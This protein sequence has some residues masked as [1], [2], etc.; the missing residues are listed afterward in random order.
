MRVEAAQLALSQHIDLPQPDH[1]VAILLTL[2]IEPMTESRGKRG[3]WKLYVALVWGAVQP[4]GFAG[5][6]SNS[7]RPHMLGV[8]RDFADG[9]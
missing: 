5:P 8:S 6:S 9:C 7:L 4:K 3:L 1:Q 2:A